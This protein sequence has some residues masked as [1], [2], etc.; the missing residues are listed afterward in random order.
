[1]YVNGTKLDR[2]L[3]TTSQYSYI[4]TPWIPGARNHHFY[5]DDHGAV[6]GDG[7]D[8][9]NAFR[10]AIAAAK[11]SGAEVWIPS[12]EFTLGSSQQVD[13]VTIRGAGAWYSVRARS[14]RGCGWRT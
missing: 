6:A 10:A 9:V 5:D 12:G 8:D 4:E 1:M 13:Q 2:R 14:C 3:N 11:S 7:Q